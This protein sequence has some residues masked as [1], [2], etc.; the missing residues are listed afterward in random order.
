MQI[1]IAFML[2]TFIAGGGTALIRIE[3]ARA[4]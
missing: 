1:I 4:S 3:H 2:F